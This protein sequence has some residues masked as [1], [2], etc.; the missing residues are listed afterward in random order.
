MSN[1]HSASIFR[2][3]VA[4]GTL[5][6]PLSAA[7]VRGQMHHVEAPQHITRAIGVYEWTGDL[8]KPHAARFVPVSLFIDGH[9]QDAGLY[10]ARPVPFAIQPGNLYDLERGGEPQGVLDLELAR[11]V[12]TG[13]ALADDN[14]TGTWYAFGRFTPESA[15]RPPALRPSAHLSRLESSAGPNTPAG[16]KLPTDTTDASASTDNRP[17]MSRRDATG[18]TPSSGSTGSTGAGGSSGSPGSTGS[19]GATGAT[20]STSSTGPTGSTRSTSSN[21]SDD[22]TDRPTLRRRDP[23]QDAAR[24]RDVGAKSKTA[25]VTAAGPALGDDPDRPILGHS[26]GEAAETPELTGLP[27]DLHQVVAVSDASHTDSHPFARAW[28]S[29]AERAATLAGLAALARP[30]VAQYLAA[31]RLVASSAALPAAGTPLAPTS[32]A[33]TPT[34]AANA[35]APVPNSDNDG[36]N[37]PKLQRGVPKA[38]QPD[39]SPAAKT[40]NPANPVTPANLGDSNRGAPSSAKARP[41][42]KVGP[43]AHRTTTTTHRAGTSTAGHPATLTLGQEEVTGFTLSYGGL[44][45]FVYTAAASISPAKATPGAAS[46]A[47]PGSVAYVTVVA[48]RLPSGELQVA[49]SN[50]TDNAHLDRGYRLRLIDAVDPDDTHRASLLFELRGASARQFALYRLTAAQAEQTFTTAALE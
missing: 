27:A 28:D 22:D 47:N 6:L 40:P 1:R 33:A 41:S 20:G 50:V 12:V 38:Y 17:H 31:N 49:L 42:P 19:T 21:S 29:L 25:S 35:Q 46:V 23:A 43:A 3:R 7:A 18:T 4:A 26:S 13:K 5:L 15:P 34:T 36:P 14:P 9:L 45:T 24:R 48:Q 32:Q 10:L 2:F 8:S 11:R 16:K 37:P 44:P 30:R 39:A